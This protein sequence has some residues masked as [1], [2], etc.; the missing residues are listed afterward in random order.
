MTSLILLMEKIKSIETREELYLEIPKGGIGAEIGV[1]KGI[2]SMP[3]YRFH[4]FQ[5]L[6]E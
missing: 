4:S 2:N 3:L 6:I 1:C 5:T